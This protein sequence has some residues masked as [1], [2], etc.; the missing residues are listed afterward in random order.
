MGGWGSRVVNL[1]KC[2]NTRFLR[3][4]WVGVKSPKLDISAMWVLNWSGRWVGGVRCLGL[5]PK[6]IDFF[7]APSLS[8]GIICCF[9]PVVEWELHVQGPIQNVTLFASFCCCVQ[10]LARASRLARQ[11]REEVEK[12]GKPGPGSHTGLDDCNP[13]RFHEPCLIF[14]FATSSYQ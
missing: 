3:N 7:W 9:D 1:W 10:L 2:E 8:K 13:G 12:E 11:V 4:F 14:S 5:F 6:K